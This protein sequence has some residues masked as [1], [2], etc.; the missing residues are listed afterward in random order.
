MAVTLRVVGIFFNATFE[1]PTPAAAYPVKSVMDRAA[2]LAAMGEL[3]LYAPNPEPV[4]ITMFGYGPIGGIYAT[5]FIAGYGKPFI[6]R[7]LNTPYGQGN[8]YLEESFT[9]GT[10]APS[11]TNWQYYV[12]DANGDAISYKDT[13]YADPRVVV[14]DGGSVIWRCVTILTGPS[15]SIPPK[16]LKAMTTR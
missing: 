5:Q 9:P 8:Y 2:S 7:E 14:P 6:T 1:M 11:Y 15:P 4:P 13:S 12:S 10:S 16:V 3:A